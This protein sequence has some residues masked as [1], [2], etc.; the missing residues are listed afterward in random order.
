MAKA[1]VGRKATA[2]PMSAMKNAAANEALARKEEALARELARIGGHDPDKHYHGK[3]YWEW[4]L[5]DAQR[6]IAAT[7]FLATYE[8]EQG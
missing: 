2:A 1:P 7:A 5:P 6:F 3:R 4:A 8:E